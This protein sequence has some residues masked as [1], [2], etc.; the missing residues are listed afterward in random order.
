MIAKH[1]NDLERN[2]PC[3]AYQVTPRMDQ[4]LTRYVQGVCQVI[5]CT[6]T[7]RPCDKSNHAD[8][9]MEPPSL[10]TLFFFYMDTVSQNQNIHIAG[11]FE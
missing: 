8:Q 2:G 3:L 10:G 5:S 6:V 11:Y 1:W 7:L 4:H 9:D